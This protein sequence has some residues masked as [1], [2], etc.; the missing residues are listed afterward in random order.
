MDQEKIE[1]I[2][3][4]RRD[5]TRSLFT[6]V[7]LPDSSEI[8]AK[9]DQLIR[10][11]NAS[12]GIVGDVELVFSPG[13]WHENLSAVWLECLDAVVPELVK[14]PDDD[15]DICMWDVNEVDLPDISV[16]DSLAL[17]QDVLGK[18]RWGSK[19]TKKKKNDGDSKR[20]RN[21]LFPAYVDVVAGLFSAH[22]H[23]PKS[24]KTVPMLSQLVCELNIFL[25]GLNKRENECIPW[26][27]LLD[28]VRKNAFSKI[29]QRL[30][31]VERADIKTAQVDAAP[32]QVASD[33]KKILI[34]IRKVVDGDEVP[35][36]DWETVIV[37]LTELHS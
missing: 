23:P 20:M 33:I 8:D 24:M 2:H 13:T 16:E 15:S 6:L 11:I 25:T 31:I 9:I 19:K 30:G 10:L 35:D 27:S 29:F 3:A 22:L 4:L 12:S 14:I 32:D 28:H 37:Q 21:D 18:R 5:V 26:R 34:L 7:L 36:E 1:E 17:L